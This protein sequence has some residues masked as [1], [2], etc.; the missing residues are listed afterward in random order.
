M[1]GLSRKNLKNLIY[2]HNKTF[3]PPHKIDSKN[4]CMLG[5]SYWQNY[6]IQNYNYQ[7]NSWGFR[8]NDYEQYIDQ[9][10]NI[11]IGDSATINLGGPVEHSW[12]WLLSQYFDIPTLNLGLDGLSFTEFLQVVDKAKTYF[13]LDKIFVLYNIFENDSEPINNIVV[14]V[15][16]NAK[17]D[18][19]INFLKKYCWV[20]G[21]YWQ[22]DP[23]WTFF[24]DEV[25]CLYEHFPEAHDYLKTYKV[26]YNSININLLLQFD[27]LKTEYYKISG[28]SWISYE[29]FCEAFLIGAN[30][31]DYFSAAVDQRLINEYLSIHFVPTIEKMLLTNRDG[32]HMSRQVNQALADYF[33]QQTLKSY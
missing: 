9:P 3:D 18:S 31:L 6:P 12:P 29:K 23:P 11:C 1:W 7:Y 22:F 14:P 21:A 28:P 33:Y 4:M 24:S 20:H 30:V 16:N 8:G 15:L 26:D 17:I 32:W 13:K 27:Q 10:V 5:P 2:L 25:P 19:K